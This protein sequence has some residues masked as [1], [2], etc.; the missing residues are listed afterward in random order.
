MVDNVTDAKNTQTRKTQ[1]SV[2]AYQAKFTHVDQQRVPRRFLV[3]HNFPTTIEFCQ[4][5]IK[6]A[7]KQNSTYTKVA[8]MGLTTP[9]LNVAIQYG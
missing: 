5:E 7:F 9:A 1:E 8:M 4:L 6:S 2:C 3:A